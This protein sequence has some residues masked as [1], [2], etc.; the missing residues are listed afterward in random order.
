M[1]LIDKKRND[2]PT[3]AG[4]IDSI[5]DT[6][7]F[8]YRLLAALGC[9]PNLSHLLDGLARTLAIIR[10]QE[11]LF[12]SMLDVDAV[13]GCSLATLESRIEAIITRQNILLS[14]MDAPERVAA[15][16]ARTTSSE[17]HPLRNYC[18]STCVYWCGLF[19]TS[20]PGAPA[21]EARYDNLFS[22]LAIHFLSLTAAV[23]VDAYEEFIGAWAKDGIIPTDLPAEMARFHVR[24]ARAGLAARRLTLPEHR[25][26]YDALSFSAEGETLDDRLYGA[27]DRPDSDPWDGHNLP[28]LNDLA[29]LFILTVPGWTRPWRVTEQELSQGTRKGGGGHEKLPDG[30]V[31]IAGTRYAEQAIRLDTGEAVSI[32]RLITEEGGS[33]MNE[34]DDGEVGD[35]WITVTENDSSI[36][37]AGHSIQVLQSRRQAAHIARHH[38]QL[39][40]ALDVPTQSELRSVVEWLRKLGTGQNVWPMRHPEIPLLIAISLA[41]GRS[42]DEIGDAGF[43]VDDPSATTPV[44]YLT[45]QRVWRILINGPVYASGPYSAS[46]N[47]HSINRV[48]ELP[49]FGF[50]DALLQRSGISRASPFQ[51]QKLTLQARVAVDETL[52][53]AAGDSHLTAAMLPR[54]LFRLLLNASRGDL[55]IASMLTGQRVAHSATTL[56][57]STYSAPILQKVYQ[58]AASAIWR[59]KIPAQRD[60][61]NRSSAASTYYGSRQ[62]PRGEAV[63]KLI[64]HLGSPLQKH[65]VT[66]PLEYHNRYT[67]Y[68][69]AAQALGL[70]FR[71]VVSP[72]VSDWIP[73]DGLVTFTDKARAD[74]HRRV[75]YVPPVI[76]R[77]LLNYA[78]HRRYMAHSYAEQPDA[79][80]DSAIFVLWDATKGEFRPFRPM[81]FDA[82]S[83]DYGLPLRSLRHFMRTALVCNII[84]ASSS[85]GTQVELVD[86][87]MGHWH[88]GLSPRESGSTFNPKLLKRLANGHVAR[89]LRELGIVAYSSR[90]VDNG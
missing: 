66:A 45:T 11:E 29:L 38:Q 53:S 21:G 86:A 82:F 28:I 61:P 75:S 59:K 56:H 73:R 62:C 83:G 47:E 52:A 9:P 2:H 48:I 10:A 27:L 30:F 77:L 72:A 80:S 46:S 74:Y 13:F 6:P 55:A 36:P 43:W 58:A 54:V 1:A 24:L 3:A 26:A 8:G 4:A 90:Y 40:L 88:I 17:R 78:D 15:P 35:E 33:D 22:E 32:I 41:T 67:A 81:D 5:T 44:T 23:D 76:G 79:W 31:R 63:T 50:F 87:W 34:Q 25:A 20:P 60:S 85:R 7:G 19:Y 18:L 89:L 71:G 12:A 68:V 51:L 42:I 64:Q 70:G 69:V 14:R 39:T 57:Y 65:G 16:M 49:D 37:G 84:S